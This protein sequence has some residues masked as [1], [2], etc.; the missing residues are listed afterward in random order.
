MKTILRV[1]L[2]VIAGLA[3]ACSVHSPLTNNLAYGTPVAQAIPPISVEDRGVIRYEVPES[4]TLATGSQHTWELATSSGDEVQ[5]QLASSGWMPIWEVRGGTGIQTNTGA[6][7]VDFVSTGGT[8]AIHIGERYG[9]GTYRLLV[10]LRNAPT[11]APTEAVTLGTGDVQVTL[12]WHTLDD[13]DL[14]VIDPLGEEIY[15]AH[16]TSASGGELDVDMNVGCGSTRSPVENVFW[17]SGEA[18]RGTYRVRVNY[19]SACSVDQRNPFEVTVKIVG[20]PDR[21]YEGVLTRSGDTAD[22]VTFSY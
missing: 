9:G 18:P 2:G 21:V 19:Y 17:H 6:G 10:Q 7:N 14:H 13:L 12:R 15:Y 16:S 8:Y 22:V 3:I 5:V 20:Q 1:L 4:A 11:P